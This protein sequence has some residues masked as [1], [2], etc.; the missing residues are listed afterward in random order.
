MQPPQVIL[1]PKLLIVDVGAN[2]GAS[3]VRFAN[4]FPKASIFAIEPLRRNFE[5]LSFN[6]IE[7]DN[8]TALE[9][10]LGADNRRVGIQDQSTIRSEWQAQVHN[11]FNSNSAEVEQIDMTTLLN[12][13]QISHID[14]LKINVEGYETEILKTFG[15]WHRKVEVIAIAIRSSVNFESIGNSMNS[16]FEFRPTSDFCYH[17][18]EN[19][20]LWSFPRVP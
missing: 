15:S 16:L 11:D 3:T 2:I 18:A 12:R 17:I 7:Y 10:A 13:Y 19:R 14:L 4:Q 1:P 5:R 6:T 8:I 20:I 9:Y